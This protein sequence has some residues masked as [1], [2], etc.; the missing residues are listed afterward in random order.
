MVYFVIS[1]HLKLSRDGT[2]DYTTLEFKKKKRSSSFSVRTVAS[3]YAL[4]Y[5]ALVVI[6]S[7]NYSQFLSLFTSEE[8]A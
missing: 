5:L 3:V 7:P 8:Q 2:F 1:F 4:Q 6:S